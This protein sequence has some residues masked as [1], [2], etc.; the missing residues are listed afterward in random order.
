MSS[1]NNSS[2]ELFYMPVWIGFFYIQ[3]VIQNIKERIL[4]AD[5]L[6]TE[7][8]ITWFLRS[9]PSF[10]DFTMKHNLQYRK[11]GSI[12]GLTQ[13]EV[14]SEETQYLPIPTH[15]PVRQPPSAPPQNFLNFQASNLE[16][17]RILIS[18]WVQTKVFTETLALVVL[19]PYGDSPPESGCLF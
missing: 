9:S 4:G 8:Q 1:E 5:F 10:V 15:Y 18:V 12:Q 13:K 17:S 3:Q 16:E 7:V 2:L 14:D 19:G 11:M 6:P